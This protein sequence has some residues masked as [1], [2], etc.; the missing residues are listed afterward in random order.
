MR[1]NLKRWC[2]LLAVG[3][4][5]PGV[6]QGLGMVSWSGLITTLLSSWLALI[7]TVLLGGDVSDL[8]RGL[9]G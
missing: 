4:Y 8:L 1:T 3:G 6:L 7:V 5:T 2:V 9:Q